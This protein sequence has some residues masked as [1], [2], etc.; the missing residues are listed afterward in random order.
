MI[1]TPARITRLDNGTAWVASD[2]PPSCGACGGKGC[3]SSLFARVWHPSE[4]EYRV[5]NPIGAGIGEQVVVGVPDGALLRATL[6]SYVAPV[7]LLLLGAMLGNSLSGEPG[8]VIGGLCGLGL[9]AGWLRLRRADH[10]LPVILR[11]DD[12]TGHQCKSRHG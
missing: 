6:A 1:E 12:G 3:G 7:L 5:D 9:A 4:P 8:A 11:R 2:A 10:A